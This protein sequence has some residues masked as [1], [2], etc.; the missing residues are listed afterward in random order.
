MIQKKKAPKKASPTALPARRRIATKALVQV[1]DATLHALSTMEM[2]RA[3]A[4]VFVLPGKPP[5]TQ[6]FGD[7]VTK[8]TPPLLHVEVDEKALA[9]ANEAGFSHA[10]ELLARGAIKLSGDARVL[11]QALPRLVAALEQAAG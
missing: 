5:R 3:G 7:E 9:A 2:P 8:K 6:N 11:A 10:A 4:V 1:A